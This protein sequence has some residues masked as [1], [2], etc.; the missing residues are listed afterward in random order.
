LQKAA[1]HL[2][3]RPGDFPECE[4]QAAEIITLPSHQYITAEQIDFMVETI[5]TFYGRPASRRSR[6]VGESGWDRRLSG[7]AE[8]RAEPLRAMYR[9]MLRI[10]R[11][12][13]RIAEVYPE[14][15]MR[16]PVHLCI[17]QEAVAAGVCAALKPDDYAMSAH[18]SHGHY[19]AKG[20]DLR[21]LVA[22]LYGRST[23]CSRGKGGSMHM[24]DL[25]C[26]FI[27]A[28]PIVGSTIP[29]AVGAAFAARM[30]GE[31]RV[32]A[33]FFGDGAT[34]EGVFHESLDFAALKKLP[35]VFVC[36]NNRFS[37]YSPLTVRQSAGRELLGLARAHGLAADRADGNDVT[38][39]VRLTETAVR[40]ARNGEGP[41]LLEFDTYRFREHCGPA[42]DDHLGYRDSTEVADWTAR[43]PV[44][45]CAEQLLRAG[46]LT[47]REI[48]AWEA[49]IEAEITDALL[50]AKDSPFPAEEEML[51]HVY[52]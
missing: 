24:I 45:R 47:A 32:V 19:L 46:Q 22:E 9:Q 4:R 20:G 51:R 13:E 1:A 44:A 12:E 11:I 6:Q 8:A 31:P 39:V 7:P 27:G 28:T 40:R 48:A 41:T 29:I 14:Q 17:G 43:D 33:V 10:R 50:F 49:E 26:G 38:E 34:E 2:G 36:E 35:V 3:Y 25:N 23:G 30:R 42:Y 21:G 18:R 5:R 37:V 52:A 16:C 15:E